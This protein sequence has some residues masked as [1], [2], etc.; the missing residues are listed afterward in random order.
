[1]VT[2][3]GGHKARRFFA[4][5]LNAVER[6]FFAVAL[7]A[8]VWDSNGLLI[9]LELLAKQGRTVNP[10]SYKLLFS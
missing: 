6:R 2:A 8:V 3:N 10:A 9:C 1:M 5:A 4:V 7:N